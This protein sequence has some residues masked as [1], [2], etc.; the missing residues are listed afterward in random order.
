MRN[1]HKSFFQFE[2]GNDLFPFPSQLPRADVVQVSSL[3]Y[4]KWVNQDQP[5]EKQSL[6]VERKRMLHSPSCLLS[7][8]LLPVSFLSLS[9][10]ICMFTRW[11]ESSLRLGRLAT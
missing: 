1:G 10:L 9:H 8:F 2:T 7:L 5:V 4:L 3:A 6:K 11:R